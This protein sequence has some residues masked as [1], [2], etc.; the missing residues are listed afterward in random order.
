MAVNFHILQSSGILSGAMHD[1]LQSVL[2]ETSN[3]CDEK[4]TLS[5][6]DVVVMNVPRNT[7]PRIGIN[8]FSYDAHQIVLSIDSNHEFLKANFEKTIA[9][10]LSHELHHSARSLARGNS[11]SQ[12]YGGSLVAEGLACC[13]E[14]EMCNTTPFYAVECNGDTLREF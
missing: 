7:I 1:Q 10:I 4:L 12:T 8:G 5:N 13:F 3:Q 11:H 14:E 6:V 2:I 9:A